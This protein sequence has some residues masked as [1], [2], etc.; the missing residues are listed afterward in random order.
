[1][2]MPT[3]DNTL[4]EQARKRINFDPTI[5]LGHILTFAGVMLAGIGAYGNLDKRMTVSEVQ[6]MVA[7]ER[8]KEQDRRIKESLQDLKVDIKDVQR[9][10]NDINRT[11]VAPEKK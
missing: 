11:L 2:T 9:A 1:M 3:S 10:V 8:T 5:N 7:A 6:N 4:P